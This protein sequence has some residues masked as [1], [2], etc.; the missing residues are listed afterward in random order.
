[1]KKKFLSILLSATLIIMD[2]SFAATAFAE[3][4]NDLAVPAEKVVINSDSNSIEDTIGLNTVLNYT[5][6]I[7]TYGSFS[8]N[9]YIINRDTLTSDDA[10]D[11][12][13]F[14]LT[15]TR[16]V[17]LTLQTTADYIAIICPYNP[18]TGDIT[19]STAYPNVR[20]G[21]TA[22]FGDINYNSQ[23]TFCLVVLNLGSDYGAYYTIAMNAQNKGYANQIVNVS[24]NFRYVTLGYESGEYT[25]NGENI[26]S[27]VQSYVSKNVPGVNDDIAEV[28]KKE[29][30]VNQTDVYRACYV[31]VKTCQAYLDMDNLTYGT[32]KNSS[33]AMPI[34]SN[35]AIFIPIYGG[36]YECILN[37]SGSIRAD[38]GAPIDYLVY[39]LT[40]NS[41]IDWASTRNF[42]Y[43]E[44]T[45]MYTFEMQQ[46]VSL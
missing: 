9:D 44:N 4:A 35:A 31:Y 41:I 6:E 32:Y 38:Q 2:N 10:V 37:V 24:D 1:M 8:G 43:N 25:M 15:G 26:L 46:L 30:I 45:D 23:N 33:T 20:K 42:F 17:L 39:D 21:E 27:G 18:T 5:P 19:V 40:T 12:Y 11:F 34:S 22:A 16:T 28:F 7:Q 3:S 14:T 29:Y 36:H 13:T